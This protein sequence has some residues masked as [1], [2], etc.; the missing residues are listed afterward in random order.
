M[1][2]Y[3]SVMLAGFKPMEREVQESQSY[4][5]DDGVIYGCS[6]WYLSRVSFIG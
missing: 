6:L 5:F 3:Q 1:E 2:S 4:T